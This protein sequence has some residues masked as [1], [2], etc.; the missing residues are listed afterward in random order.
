MTWKR[1]DSINY[2]DV[3]QNARKVERFFC[4]KGNSYEIER[5]R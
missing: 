4:G 5:N 2:Q 1:K 3:S